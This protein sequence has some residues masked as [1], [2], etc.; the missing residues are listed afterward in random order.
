MLNASRNNRLNFIDG[1]ITL[2]E[3]HMSLQREVSAKPSVCDSPLKL[4]YSVP[5][6]EEVF[7]PF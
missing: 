2:D 5:F 1:W 6:C 7:S 4:A 3:L